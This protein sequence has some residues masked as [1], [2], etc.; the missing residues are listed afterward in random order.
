MQKK[1]ELF[2]R[3]AQ[4]HGE[5]LAA[6]IINF[7][8]TAAQIKLEINVQM[9]FQYRVDG[10]SPNG[11]RK[12]EYVIAYLTKRFP[13]ATPLFT[14][15]MDF[16]RDLPHLQPGRITEFPEPCLIDGAPREFF[17][18]FG[19]AEVGI[20]HLI[21]Q[22]AIWL[23]KAATSSL[24]DYSQGWEPTL[25][26]NL[27]HFLYLDVEAYQNTVTRKSGWKVF[28]TDFY[29]SGQK[30]DIIN[31]DLTILLEAGTEQVPLRNDKSDKQISIRRKTDDS[32]LGQTV[33]GLI[34]S[35]TDPGGKPIISSTYSPE[36]VTIMR[37]LK[38]KAA[39][40]GC[41]EQLKTF[42][43]N[44]ERY[45]RGFVLNLP[46]PVGIV[47]AV[48]RPCHLIGSK[49]DIELISY[50]FEVNASPERDSLLAS[51]DDEPVG[52]CQALAEANPELMRNLSGTPELPT[53][54]MI[55][56]GSVGSKLALHFAKSGIGV[57]SIAD[58]GYLRPHNSARHGLIQKRL[59]GNK[60]EALAKEIGA[61]GQ[62]PIV[63][64][65]DLVLGCEDRNSRALILPKSADF[66]VNSTASLA[67]RE[68]LSKLDPRASKQ[69]QIEAALFGRGEGAYLLTEGTGRNPSL[70]DLIGELYSNTSNFRQ[71]ELLFD[72]LYG[73]TQVQIGQGCGSLT[74]P[75]TDARISN[76]T[77]GLAEELQRIIAA[78]HEHGELVV[79]IKEGSSPSAHWTRQ[80]ISPF[81]IAP[82]EGVNDWQIRVS[83]RV[84]EM[85]RAEQAD[86]PD[87]ETGGVMI[88]LCS[89]RLQTITVVDLLP[90]PPDSSRSATRFVLGTESLKD[91]IERRFKDS[92][93]SLVDVG[94]WHTHLAD[95]G[96]SQLDRD[97]AHGLSKDRTP[98]SCLFIVTPNQF[99]AYM[100]AQDG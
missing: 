45:F 35:G 57:Q 64:K 23:R 38:E 33:T 72:E 5:C 99:H 41:L 66:A 55:G 62:S 30:T 52:P 34:W 36:T 32:I 10:E 63:Y 75:M 8:E 51:G 93:G 71:T 80:T 90:A 84:L 18:Q 28:N 58:S 100:E 96:P 17:F 13:W 69:R 91:T 40:L 76:M 26:Q 47:L 79:A 78:P 88:G 81:T 85:M 22:V 94:T 46:I 42:L 56:A 77:S 54:A 60:A 12:T 87:V 97:T 37:E 95:T 19:L 27:D 4:K 7:D 89:A 9:P 39:E 21:D 1:A 16:P 49:S 82:I 11:V 67:V 43:Q 61:L 86:Y 6:E 25:R 29:R 14:L 68:A 70:N 59:S 73:L 3:V 44:V 92:G 15:R 74:M 2:C 98:P 31:K 53:V 50:V 65:N 83:P 20:F 24:I 48:R